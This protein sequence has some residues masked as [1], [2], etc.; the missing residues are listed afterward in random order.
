MIHQP[1]AVLVARSRVVEGKRVSDMWE[2]A[3][4]WMWR[5]SRRVMALLLLLLS[6]LPV[7]EV[8]EMV[9]VVGAVG[10]GIWGRVER[11]V[12]LCGSWIR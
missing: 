10:G 11:V 8:E 7:V 6:L 4:V 9:V 5:A 12:W 3:C 2:R 1:R